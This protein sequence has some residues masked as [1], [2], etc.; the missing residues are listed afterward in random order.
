M[1]KPQRR[2]K[3]KFVILCE[4]ETETNYFEAI[5]K[6]RDVEV[7]LQVINMNG[8]GYKNFLSEIVN[9]P[10]FEYIACLHDSNCKGG[11]T[12]NHIMRV[13]GFKD[14]DKFKSNSSI[15]EFLHAESRHHT[16]MLGKLGKSKFIQN[17][18][19]ADKIV[20]SIIET[21]ADWNLLGHRNS[22]INEF[23]GIMQI[24]G[25]RTNDNVR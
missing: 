25:E 15:Y 1:S 19:N 24:D 3:P 6:Q 10:D 8:G 20:I 21:A 7:S 17:K 16:I 22:N 5:R 23:F 12:K 9:C 4:G 13:F 14:M 18:H 2:M 11:D